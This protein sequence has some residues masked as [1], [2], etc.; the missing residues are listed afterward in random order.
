M[1]EDRLYTEEAVKKAVADGAREGVKEGM[2]IGMERLI[3]YLQVAITR[4]QPEAFVEFVKD[5]K[6]L[7]FIGSEKREID[8]YWLVTI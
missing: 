3:E 5:M 7:P 6:P 2:K 1:S 8:T 4:C